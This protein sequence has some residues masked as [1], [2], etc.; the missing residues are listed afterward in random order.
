MDYGGL[1][2]FSEISR[3]LWSAGQILSLSPA[4]IGDFSKSYEREQQFPE[5]V[6]SEQTNA[7]LF[8]RLSVEASVP[9][10]LKRAL[11]TT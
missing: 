4:F 5:K 2:Q 3:F 6:S 9:D 7:S 1:G 8:T 10:A 11:L